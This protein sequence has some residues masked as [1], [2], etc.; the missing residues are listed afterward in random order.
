MSVD[1]YHN[2]RCSK[3][4]QTLEILI[5]RNIKPRVIKYLETPPDTNE[6]KVLMVKLGITQ[7][8]DMMRTKE[9]LYKELGLASADDETLLNAIAAHPKLLERPIVVSNGR[10]KL[11]RPPE[12][13][14]EI[15]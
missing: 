1:I 11:G 6:L 7:V 2:P 9:T 4:R 14:I 13:V 3:S 8:R 5:Q 15:L 10:A 12:Q